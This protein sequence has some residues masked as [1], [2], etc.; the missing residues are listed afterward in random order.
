MTEIKHVSDTATWVAFYRAEETKRSDALFR[1]PLAEKLVGEKGEALARELSA[2]A[3]YTRQNVVIRTYLIDQF[4]T[5]LV[6]SGVDT[7][8]NLGAGLDTRPY[9]LDLPPS[10][11]WIEVDYPHVIE[12][13]SERLKDETPRL[14]LERVALDLADA[15]LRRSLFTRL[16]RGRVAVLTEG[17]LPYLTEDAVGE[18]ADDLR[19]CSSFEF[20][21]CDYMSPDTYRM[22]RDPNRMKKMKN[23]P[24]QFF[25]PNPFAFFEAH[26]WKRKDI[27]YIQQTTR[28]LGRLM[29]APWYGHILKY[30]M[31]LAVRERFLKMSG[32]MILERA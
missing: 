31:P 7:I 28:E 1:D 24:F 12:M 26:G 21:I 18:L 14:Q 8:V 10:I 16:N 29:P 27:R 30:F 19:A 2:T 22:L 17:V 32:Y 20:W 5:E 9:R 4:I 25:P 15:N 6:A 3:A 11:R 23:A 13:K